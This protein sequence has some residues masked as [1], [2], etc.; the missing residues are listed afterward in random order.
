MRAILGVLILLSLFFNELSWAQKASHFHGYT[1]NVKHEKSQNFREIFIYSY[2]PDKKNKLLEVIFNPQLSKE[3]KDRYREKFGELDTESLIYLNS[4]TKFI[5]APSRVPLDDEIENQKRRDYAEYM[6]KRLTEWHVDNYV[7]TEPAVRPLYETKERLSHIE[8]KVSEESKLDFRYD[9]AA[10]NLDLIYINPWVETKYGLEMDPDAFGPS[11]TIESK[12]KLEKQIN[13]SL[14]IKSHTAF[15][16]GIT[17]LEFE[18]WLPKAWMFRLAGSTFFKDQGVTIRE[19]KIDL[20]F[21][22]SY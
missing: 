13:S 1:N 8:V 18:K 19:S 20:G 22:K 21:S 16:D 14:R 9:L 3:F 4:R 10:N 5:E 2:V 7:K 15:I 6:I 11:T 12:L 17:R